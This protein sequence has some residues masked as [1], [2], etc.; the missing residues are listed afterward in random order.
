MI[1]THTTNTEVIQAN[2][3]TGDSSAVILQIILVMG[4][5]GISMTV[6]WFMFIRNETRQNDRKKKHQ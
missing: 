4:I 2:L 1:N 5:I 6:G 3:F